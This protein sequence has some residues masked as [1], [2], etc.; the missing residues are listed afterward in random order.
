MTDKACSG[1]ALVIGFG[2]IGG[3]HARILA[4]LG[5]SVAVVS[6]HSSAS[7]D[8]EFYPSIAAALK[9]AAY[10]YA[11][12]A[13]ETSSHEADLQ[14]LAQSG[15][16]GRMMVE[17][18]LY[19]R[20]PPSIPS[21]PVPVHVGYQLRFHPCVQ[22]LRDL[23]KDRRCLT[24]QFYVGQHLDS[25]R[26]GRSGRQSYSSRTSQ[27]GGVL[28]DLSHELDL[29]QW[30]FGDCRNVTALGG[31]FADVTEDSDDAWGILGKFDHCPVVSL[32]MNY[33]DR[34]GQR[35]IVVVA[36]DMSVVADLVH[37]TVEWDG[38]MERLTCDRDGPIRDMHRDILE[39]GGQ[40]ACCFEAGLRVMRMIEAIETAGARNQWVT[41]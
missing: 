13:T 38:H 33:L 9:T 19:S 24:A 26:I 23:L 18:P 34:I 11:V 29:A 28:R 39:N 25:W 15:G 17:K 10:N 41:L 7:A 32:Q 16:G 21:Y 6:R 31:R 5:L 37:G 27:G 14:A 35:R 40:E 2:S 30:L 8:F 12:V 22:R 1:R 4:E 20:I 36:E 3:R